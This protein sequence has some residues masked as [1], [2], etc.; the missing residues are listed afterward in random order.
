MYI[1]LFNKTNYELLSSLLTIDD[2]IEYAKKN[3]L[4]SIG[5]CDN[6][7]YGTMEFINKCQ[8]N[9]IKPI[10]G[11][12]VSI[13]DYNIQ[14]YCKN[15]LG[16]QNI[17]KLSTIQSKRKIT[18][19]DLKKYNENLIIILQYK[20]NKYYKE[21]TNI[22]EEVYLGYSNKKEE[23]ESLLITENIVFFKENRYLK[24][25]DEYILNYLYRI[26]DSKKIS[27]D[28]IY[29]TN[30]LDLYINNINN[31]TDNKGLLNVLKIVNN[32]NLEIEKQ[33]D[34]LPKYDCENPNEY[35]FNLAKKGL[36]KRLAGNITEEYKNRFTKEMKVIT[37]MGFSNYFLV[38]YD[39]IRYAKINNILV[40]VGRG[41]AAGSLIAYCLGITEIDPIK[42]DLLFE[43]FLNPDRVTMPDIDT[44]FPD[45]KREEVINYVIEKYGKNKVAGIITFGTLS[46]KQVIRDTSR[47][48]NIPLYK[49]DEICNLIPT[50]TKEKLEYF[51]KEN[52]KFK[53]MID[54]DKTLSNM[55]VIAKRIE[56]FP[57][58]TS[59]HAAGIVMSSRNLDE[60]IPLTLSDNMYLT[61]YTMDYLEQLGILK[62]D[63][64]AIK[65]LTIISNIIKEINNNEKLTFKDIPL[66]DEKTLSIFKDGNT[67]GIFQFESFGMKEF[68]KKLKPTNMEDLFAAISLFRPGPAINIDTY[69]KRLH[70][71]EKV[72]YLDESIKEILKKTYG[73]I[74]YQEQIMSIA[75]VYAGYTFAEADLLR[76]AMS[77]KKVDILI[78]EKEKFIKKS[79][80]KGR[81]EKKS[82]ILFDLIL[83]FAGYGFNRSHAVA[84]AITSYKMAYLKANYPI[85]FYIN[86][87]NNV[88]GSSI[89]TKEYIM[90]IKSNNILIEK[91]C[92]NKS[93]DIYTYNE[94]KI[95][96]PFT[97]INSIGSSQA[98]EIINARN[99]ED[100]KDI[101]D[102]FKRLVKNKVSKKTID[103]LI[104]ADV[105][106]GFGYNKATL[107]YNLDSLYNYAELAKDLSEDI[108]QKPQLIYQRN[109]NEKNLLEIEKQTY[110]F[111]ISNH[112]TSIYRVKENNNIYLN[113]I[114]KYFNKEIEVIIYVE[115]LKLIIT[116]KG[117]KMLFLTGSDETANLEFTLFPKTFLTYYDIKKGDLIKVTG[118]V[119]KR[120]NDYQIIVNKVKY[121]EEENE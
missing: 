10:V 56:G 117:D 85:I 67:T 26:R 52:E 40:G 17:I 19:E 119:E 5:I 29:D 38:V 120:L 4:D 28:I 95:I 50:V 76:R 87:L 75:K 59:I 63:F 84:Y 82:N 37:E 121:L 58:H 62:M 72:T 105:L 98:K 43:R 53:Y 42:Y 79:K 97:S 90:E 118:R 66:N 107:E 7:M 32:C 25:K 14:I 27:D 16:Y 54:S 88:I 83:N 45:D 73:I 99:N 69:I 15:Y 9:N 94:N 113:N 108:I 78:K 71:E 22:Y 102:I 109:Y 77:K 36:Y 31:L 103:T 18:I 1:P 33:K 48:L 92:I 21:I 41:S 65:N 116:K 96:L 6:T 114:K 23:L 34:I 101:Y 91:P 61:S 3:N 110:G 12:E 70:N 81:D 30:N 89:K 64:L 112:P 104:V 100:F 106:N 46:V 80:E 24:L 8:S 44:D 57:R 93:L 35:L 11:L 49:V 39:F 86:L 74:I 47:M 115:K 20:Y 68:L 13:T 60:I 2:L 55:Y 51:Y 111:Y